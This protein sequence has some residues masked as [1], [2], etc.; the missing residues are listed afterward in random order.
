MLAM[1]KTTIFVFLCVRTHAYVMYAS[2]SLHVHLERITRVY[3][4][5]GV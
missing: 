5:E 4:A 1:L 3:F 2:V